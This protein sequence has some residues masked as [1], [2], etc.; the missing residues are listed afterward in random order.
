MPDNATP[1]FSTR[2]K[3]MAS[4]AG[5]PV[6]PEPRSAPEPPATPDAPTT[7]FGAVDAADEQPTG[8]FGPIGEE[9]ERILVGEL[10]GAAQPAD[11]T[12]PPEAAAP[13]PAPTSESTPADQSTHAGR[14]AP[15]PGA[16][17]VASPVTP[18]QRAAAAF[19]PLAGALTKAK[20]IKLP[21]MRRAA[22]G[23][24]S[25]SGPA[26]QSPAAAAQDPA[27]QPKPSFAERASL[28]RRLKVLRARR[29]VG[30]L[31]LGAI[32]LDQQRFGDAS[33][34]VLTRKRTD[35]LIELDG[36]IATIEHALD[37]EQSAETLTAQLGVTPC[38]GC[39]A[40]LGPRDRFCSECGTARGA[41][42]AARSGA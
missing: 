37:E 20:Q 15:D 1:N 36:E 19:A 27:G 7:N 18:R 9:T 22:A 16:T 21:A 34:G 42:A 41:D 40:L 39:G 26:A 32:V 24:V 38:A 13:S 2:L 5:L 17:P 10:G 35:E 30:L 8:L 11:P 3:R 14:P 12:P 23:G 31:E 33:G 6:A 25:P 4:R 29:D 28:R